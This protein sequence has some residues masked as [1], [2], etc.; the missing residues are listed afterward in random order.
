MM[1]TPANVQKMPYVCERILGMDRGCECRSE[2]AFT[3]PQ[4]RIQ[5]KVLGAGDKFPQPPAEHLVEAAQRQGAKLN[6]DP[7]AIL[8]RY[9]ACNQ[10]SKPPG[11]TTKAN[12]EPAE[13][14]PISSWTAVVTLDRS[15]VVRLASSA[16]FEEFQQ[17]RGTVH[18][19]QQTKAQALQLL[20]RLALFQEAAS[21]KRTVSISIATTQRS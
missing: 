14:P 13:N 10:I 11:I 7:H 15:S 12:E 20:Q 17:I 2:N 19:V 9:T 18:T 4:N 21:E 16:H 3:K 6:A 8:G 1:G 5:Q